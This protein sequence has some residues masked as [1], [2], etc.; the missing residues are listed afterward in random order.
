MNRH[1]T[2]L[3]LLYNEYTVNSRLDPER[4]E[5]FMQTISCGIGSILMQGLR[6][7]GKTPLAIH[8]CFD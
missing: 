7:A 5:V 2:V 6:G 4:W 8:V 3:L 1:E